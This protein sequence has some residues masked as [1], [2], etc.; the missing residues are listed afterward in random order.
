MNKKV[1]FL[2][3]PY[4]PRTFTVMNVP[5][6]TLV[7]IGTRLELGEVM[8]SAL[9]LGSPDIYLPVENWIEKLEPNFFAVRA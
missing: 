7:L 2:N 5:F 4:A 3:T 8:A 6:V 9:V 1:I